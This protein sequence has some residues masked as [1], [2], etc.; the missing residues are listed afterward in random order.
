MSPACAI[1]LC[2]HCLAS[3]ALRRLTHPLLFL[4]RPSLQN[5]ELQIIRMMAHPNIV[6]L[7]HCFYTSTEK[8]EVR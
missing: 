1:G 8:D 7:K 3:L 5:R 2:V 4:A 6:Q